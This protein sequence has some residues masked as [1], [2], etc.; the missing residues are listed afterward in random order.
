M[1]GYEPPS[2]MPI[3]DDPHG[4]FKGKNAKLSRPVPLDGNVST[5]IP[6]RS[7][8]RFSRLFIVFSWF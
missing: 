7:E 6:K 1:F 2:R 8:H 4:E 5:R 3:V